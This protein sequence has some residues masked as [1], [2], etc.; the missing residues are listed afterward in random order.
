M[1]PYTQLTQE[2]RYQIS[3]LLHTQQT[4]TTIAQVLGVHKSTVSR[5]VRRNRVQRGYRPHQAHRLALQRRQGKAIPRIAVATWRGID[6]Q[7]R[8]DWS[9]EQIS[10]WLKREQACSVTPEWIYQHI[11]QDKATGGDLHRHLRCR[12]RRRK[13]Y[14]VYDR[15]GQLANRV[16]I[17]ARPAIV[18]DRS[19][20]GDWEVDT[21]IGCGHQQALVSLTERRSRLT[22]LQKVVRKTADKVSEAVRALLAPLASTVHTLTS[23][24]GKEFADHERI[25]SELDAAFFFAHPYASW[26]RGLNENTNG[27]VRQYFPKHHRFATITQQEVEGVMNKL[28]HRPRKALGFRTPAEVFYNQP[29]VALA[30]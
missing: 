8:E 20:L 27:L 30:S 26:E 14:G 6:T 5:E 22:L 29:S 19:R 4:Q 10:G 25:A 3:A 13:R 12:K 28:N 15:R 9:P 2:A 18:T 16:S 11:L 7:L 24:S 17:D 21:I 1:R 23:D